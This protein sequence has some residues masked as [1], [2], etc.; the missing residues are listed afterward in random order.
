M[1]AATDLRRC[2]VAH[3]Q[4]RAGVATLQC[5]GAQSGVLLHM[6]AATL[7][8]Q[9][10]A[11]CMFCL[12]TN[13]IQLCARKAKSVDLGVSRTRI[14]SVASWSG[15]CLDS[16]PDYSVRSGGHMNT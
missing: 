6:N 11:E 9:V 10:W 1:T 16:R 12:H 5:C 13:R 4:A 15:N 2:S 3:Q 14:R 7:K 8:A